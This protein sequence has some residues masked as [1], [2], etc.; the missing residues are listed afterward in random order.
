[1]EQQPVANCAQRAG[2]C[3]TARRVQT[4]DSDT[5]EKAYPRYKATFS[6][7]VKWLCGDIFDPTSTAY[8]SIQ[9]SRRRR[10]T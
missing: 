7:L 1:M 6:A 8:A 10:L 4:G 2:F 9:V 5:P 3:K